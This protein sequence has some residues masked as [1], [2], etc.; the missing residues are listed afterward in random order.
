MGILYLQVFGIVK[1]EKE[2]WDTAKKE[3]FNGIKFLDTTL[4]LRTYLVGDKLT[5]ADLSVA[6][7][8]QVAFKLLFD[9]KARN[10][11]PHLTR[12]FSN[13]SSLPPFI[14]AFGETHLCQ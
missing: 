1:Y 4:K 13:V 10:Q 5:S 9:A 2:K 6:G 7:V 3:L 8:L 11:Y 14:E 12:W